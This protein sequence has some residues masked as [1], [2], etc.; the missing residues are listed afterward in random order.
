MQLPKCF[1]IRRNPETQTREKGPVAAEEANPGNSEAEQQ[2]GE[3]E[4]RGRRSLEEVS[5][6]T[7]RTKA[8]NLYIENGSP[9]EGHRPNRGRSL[10]ANDA[11]ATRD[12]VYM[13]QGSLRAQRAAGTEPLL[14]STIHTHAFG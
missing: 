1:R 8:A 12:Q 5:Q 14:D 11:P 6:A 10:F 7:G 3:D 2:W 13:E 9:R 4:S